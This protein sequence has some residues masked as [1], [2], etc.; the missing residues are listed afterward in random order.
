MMVNVERRFV[1]VADRLEEVDKKLHVCGEVAAILEKLA[2]KMEMLE[3]KIDFLN[4]LIP[5]LCPKDEL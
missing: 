1:V 4:A 5:S 3:E 2:G